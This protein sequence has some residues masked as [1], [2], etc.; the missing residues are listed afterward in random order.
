[1]ALMASGWPLA[2]ATSSVGTAGVTLADGQPC[3]SVPSVRSDGGAALRLHSLTVTRTERTDWRA[4]PQELWGF[5]V[6]PPGLPLDRPGEACIRYGH[7]PDAA[8]VR[9]EARPL[10]PRQV[11]RVEINARPADGGGSTLG[12]QA[13]FCVWPLAGGAVE[14]RAVTWDERMRR[15]REEVCEERR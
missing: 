15:W 12:Y 2:C 8:R 11:Y 5:T 14:V 13:R 4:L 9:S 7:L 10:Q 1:M 6:E 3:F